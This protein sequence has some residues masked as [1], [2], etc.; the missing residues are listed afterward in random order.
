M[1][2]LTLFGEEHFGEGPAPAVHEIAKTQPSV[3]VIFDVGEV[4]LHVIAFW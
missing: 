4:I 1:L 2:T 3:L